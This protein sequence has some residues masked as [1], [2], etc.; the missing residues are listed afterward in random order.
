MKKAKPRKLHK[1]MLQSP[2]GAASPTSQYRLAAHQ[3]QLQALDLRLG[4]ATFQQI[5]DALGYK[6]RMG[7]LHAVREARR[8]SPQ[9]AGIKLARWMERERYNRAQLALWPRVQAGD[10]EAINAWIRLSKRRCEFDGLDKEKR[11][12]VKGKIEG[13]VKLQGPAF[14][15]YAGFDPNAV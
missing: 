15:V 7:A 2:R 9:D 8:K 10:L 12:R 14:K 4:G 6:T 3:K 5:A 13:Q 1:R 11:V